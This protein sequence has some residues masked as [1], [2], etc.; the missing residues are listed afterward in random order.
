MVLGN[1]HIKMARYTLASTVWGK[2]L[3]KES[4]HSR[5]KLNPIPEV[6]FHLELKLYKIICIHTCLTFNVSF[7]RMEEQ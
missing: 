1:T 5:I 4:T 2:S 6:R 3:G 7:S